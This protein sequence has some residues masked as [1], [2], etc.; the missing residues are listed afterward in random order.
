MKLHGHNNKLETN[1]VDNE[2]QE[3]SIGDPKVVISVMRKYMY[4]NKIRTLAQEYISNARDAMREVGKGNAFEVTAPTYMNPTFKVRDF[5]PGVSPD[6]MTNVFIKYGASTKRGTNTQT[7]G[8]GIGGKIAWSYTDSF[9][10][11]T[12]ID[13]IKR[14]YVAHIGANE[15]GRLDLISTENTTEPNGTEIQVAVKSGDVD[16]FED[17]IRRVVYFWEERPTIKNCD[18]EPLIT[19]YK[20][21]TV[22]IV[23]HNNLPRFTAENYSKNPMIVIDGI[24]YS[25]PDDLLHKCK[26]LKSLYDFTREKLVFRVGNGVLEVTA[27]RE[28][29]SD[30]EQSTGYIEKMA[31]KAAMEIKTHIADAFGKV[32]G[33][34]EYI[35]TYRD[36]NATFQVEAGFAK[37]GDYQIKGEAIHGDVLQRVK[38]TDI[39]CLGRGGRTKVNKI[40]KRDIVNKDRKAFSLSLFD[41]IFFYRGQESDVVKN[42][43]I[44]RYFEQY[45][46]ILLIEIAPDETHTDP[47]TKV[48]TKTNGLADFNKAL[49]DFDLPDF[50]SLPLP[51]AVAKED[52]ARVSREKTQFCLHT[53]KRT[54]EERFLYT[55]LAD[56]TTQWLYVPL[57]DGDGGWGYDLEELKELNNY[58][59]NNSG[60]DDVKICGLA[61][62]AVKMVQG[63]ALFSPLK[64]WLDSYKASRTELNFVKLTKAVNKEAITVLTP[65]KGIEDPELVAIVK[66]YKHAEVLT[67]SLGT[68]PK[69][70][71]KKVLEDDELKDFVKRD[72]EIKKLIKSKYSL[73]EAITDSHYYR[74]REYHELAFYLNAKFKD[75]N[76]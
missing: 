6:R 43:R 44:R 19:G 50:Q 72:D 74:S 8:F 51:E 40:T 1:L 35:V 61:E 33:A 32:N 34:K 25:V 13:G 16:E 71:L 48:V 56:N 36:L 31:K 55:T 24:I 68:L 23:E 73:I 75:G 2:R 17:A 28:N 59:I 58:L 12:W 5:G 62:R 9:T 15:E 76:P 26:I 14:S 60:T 29:I 53:L 54:S 11:V 22:E 70:L 52:R 41:H 7:G 10:I 49:K 63:N 42:K 3:F 47:Q 39:N 66:E 46:R 37:Y 18:V 45:E 67:K 64:A 4:K 38:M 69:I 65:I 20:I 30:S 27:S 21:G 57:S